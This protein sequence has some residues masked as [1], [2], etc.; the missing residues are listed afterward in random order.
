VCIPAELVASY[1]V[2]TCGA[3]A[4]LKYKH[5]MEAGV[6]LAQL[7]GSTHAVPVCKFLDSSPVHFSANCNTHVCAS[8]PIDA[9]GLLAM[10]GKLCSCRQ[11]AITS[12]DHVSKTKGECRIHVSHVNAAQG[13]SLPLANKLS[14]RTLFVPAGT[15]CASTA[16]WPQHG[17]HCIVDCNASPSQMRVLSVYPSLIISAAPWKIAVS[18]AANDVAIAR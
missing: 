6:G 13:P 5:T 11:E 17:V 18:T 14:E 1:F 4:P 16:S 10:L 9:H 8:F 12:K 7:P 3:R 15:P 2:L